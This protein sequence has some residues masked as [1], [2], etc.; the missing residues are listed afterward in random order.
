MRIENPESYT[1]GNKEGEVGVTD[2]WNYG[3]EKWCNME[4]QYMTVV[5]DL[6]HLRGQTYEM[7]ICSIGVMGVEYIRD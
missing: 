4:G 5:A 2:L 3:I 6:A 1:F 7:S